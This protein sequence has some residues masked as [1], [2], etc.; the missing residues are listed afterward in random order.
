MRAAISLVVFSNR[1]L[2]VSSISLETSLEMSRKLD[3]VNESVTM[4]N[5]KNANLSCDNEFF[6][7][8]CSPRANSF[9]LF[10]NVNI[11]FR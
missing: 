4:W 2:F 6:T 11:T 7:S 3:S 10:E 1:T 8:R 9:Y 5:E